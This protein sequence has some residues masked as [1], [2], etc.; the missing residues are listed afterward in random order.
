MQSSL[1]MVL[2][3]FTI[4]AL[5]CPTEQK[6]AEVPPSGLAGVG[7]SQPTQK[8]QLPSGHPPITGSQQKSASPKTT[9]SHGN[10]PSGPKASA[11]T[12]QGSVLEVFT[13]SNYTY[14]KIKDQSEQTHWA[15]VL[16]LDV[17]KGDQV[18]VHQQMVMENFQ[19]KTLNRTFDKIIFG[20]AQKRP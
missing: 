12:I 18:D 2:T 7:K 16:N 20:T 3:L 15:A 6:K 14:L 10:P 19:S 4:C 11:Q 13:A 5:G 17:K 8:S 1:L 9:L